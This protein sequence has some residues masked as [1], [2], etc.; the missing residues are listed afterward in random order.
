MCI[1]DS[2]QPATQHSRYTVVASH[3]A[4]LNSNVIDG[5]GDDDTAVLQAILDM[6]PVWGS[7]YLILDG[8]ALVSGLQVHSNTTIEC[9]NQ[10]CGF[11]LKSGS[12]RS[13]LENAHLSYTQINEENICLLYTSRCV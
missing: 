11:F 7:L 13:I 5:G 6:A 10:S 3:Y 8:A 12:N 1:R 9:L 4:R 2:I